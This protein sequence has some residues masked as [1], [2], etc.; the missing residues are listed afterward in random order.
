[1][2]EYGQRLRTARKEKGWMQYEMAEML[3]IS[4]PYL[5]D[6]ELGRRLPGDD[7]AG[8]IAALLGIDAV[9]HPCNRIGCHDLHA[10]LTAAESALVEERAARARLEA[11]VYSY[12][13][14]LRQIA[15]A[16]MPSTW[17]SGNIGW[18]LAGIAR[19]TLGW[20]EWVYLNCTFC[21]GEATVCPD[22]KC[23]EIC[24][25]DL[26]TDECPRM[27]ELTTPNRAALAQ[28]AAAERGVD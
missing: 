28:G 8:R 22:C 3:A 17:H 16:D 9:E 19:K 11:A 23:C 15:Q 5:C 2:S 4:T 1:M 21:E 6:I 10:R 7:V 24:D 26:H 25:V 18:Y 14:A 20:R 12:G 13:T 27:V